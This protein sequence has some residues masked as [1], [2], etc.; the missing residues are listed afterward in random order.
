L[1]FSSKF[2]TKH[3]SLSQNPGWI[4]VGP[5]EA[6]GS[7]GTLHFANK[8]PHTATQAISTLDRKNFDET[9]KVSTKP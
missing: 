2:T 6:E 9:D 4:K 8:S 3:L 7:E 1:I 5:T